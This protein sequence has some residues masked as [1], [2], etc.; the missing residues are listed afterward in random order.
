MHQS[1]IHSSPLEPIK[2]GIYCEVFFSFLFREVFLVCLSNTR[3][4]KEISAFGD[5]RSLKETKKNRDSF[6]KAVCCIARAIK[7]K[8]K[9]KVGCDVI[10]LLFQFLRRLRQEGLFG[11]RV[12]SLGTLA[13][14]DILNK[15]INIYTRKEIR[16]DYEIVN[17]RASSQRKHVENIR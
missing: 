13:R 16:N 9:D 3:K 7:H 6:K 10:C 1:Y 11:P 17:W 4:Q 15:H 14:S 5:L 2:I 12:Q 8:V